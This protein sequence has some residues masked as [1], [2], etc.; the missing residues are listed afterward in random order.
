MRRSDS[1]V[2]RWVVVTGLTIQQ[3][4]AAVIQVYDVKVAG[5]KLNDVA[6]L[7]G[8]GTFASFAALDWGGAVQSRRSIRSAR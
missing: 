1:S 3:L 8:P 2:G 7:M 6:A 4:L 5:S